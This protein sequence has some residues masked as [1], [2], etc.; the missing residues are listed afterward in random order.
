VSTTEVGRAAEAAAA[1]FLEHRDYDILAR[2]WR[3]RWHEVDI[4]A[5]SAQGVHFVEVKYRRSDY[6]G[7]GFDYITADK[8]NRLRRA[9]LHWVQINRYG[10][11]YQID[12]VSVSGALEQ[13]KLEYLPNA[14]QDF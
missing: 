9:A 8:A 10:G 5:R 4:V 13:M 3:T 2:N 1:T 6:Y 12:A 7:S 11:P 14:V